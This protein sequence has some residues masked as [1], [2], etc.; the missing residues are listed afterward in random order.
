[1]A[2][3][4]FHGFVFTSECGP[5]IFNIAP[6]GSVVQQTV[7]D[8]YKETIREGNNNGYLKIYTPEYYTSI[9]FYEVGIP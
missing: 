9:Y 6:D 3:A 8:W 4:Y 2:V 1:M 7:A 5:E